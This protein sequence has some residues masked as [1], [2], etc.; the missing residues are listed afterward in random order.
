MYKKKTNNQFLET[1]LTKLKDWH[2]FKY[3]QGSGKSTSLLTLKDKSVGYISISK[4]INAQIDIRQPEMNWQS[5]LAE[6]NTS[7]KKDLSNYV[8]S[9]HLTCNLVNLW[10]WEYR[11]E[12]LDILFL[13]EADISL[14]GFFTWDLIQKD[15]RWVRSYDELMFR[16]T[17]TPLVLFMGAQS[18]GIVRLM[19][20]RIIKRPH[21]LHENSYKDLE[22]KQ[23]VLCDNSKQLKTLIERQ[24]EL[25]LSN[26]EKHGGVYVASENTDL[27]SVLSSDWIKR[28][29]ELKTK[30]VVKN[31]ALSNEELEILADPNKQQDWDLMLCSPKTKD[32][33]H[34]IGGFD[35][36]AGR[37]SGKAL[38]GDEEV[39]NALLRVRTCKNFA[40][41]VANT[42]S[43][44]KNL[45][46]S[47]AFEN[48]QAMLVSVLPKFRRRNRTTGEIERTDSDLQLFTQFSELRKKEAKYGRKITIPEKLE[49]RGMDITPFIGAISETIPESK[50]TR[51]DKLQLVLEA[52]PYRAN[53]WGERKDAYRLIN[54]E[55]LRVYGEVNGENYK[56]WDGGN[57]L[58]NFKRAQELGQTELNGT[59]VNEA[60]V[61]V[62]KWQIENKKF[63]KAFI[64]ARD[65]TGKYQIPRQVLYDSPMWKQLIEDKDQW[66]TFFGRIGL[67]DIEIKDKHT[68]PDTN[69]GLDLYMRLLRKFNY[70][71]EL[72]DAKPQKDKTL[73]RK[74][75]ETKYKARLKEWRANGNSRQGLEKFFWEKL[76]TGEEV[77]S[78]I[79]DEALTFLEC[80]PYVL[81]HKDRLSHSNYIT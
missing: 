20:E 38:I 58:E 6:D 46:S 57:F 63:M 81:I 10:V 55:I 70:T 68:N 45:K 60:R 76:I 8:S 78:D 29:P 74:L 21:T 22:G 62:D 34:V 79:T 80:F 2:E 56:R 50:K 27:L 19:N 9:Q 59:P 69:L 44:E 35:L 17:T 40:L 71:A 12:P 43:V 30:I 14:E 65:K 49:E 32:G 67:S 64:V 72:V 52:K 53:E 4:I 18:N 42:K 7:I 26:R 39:I 31:K 47:D 73:T 3:H 15:D 77:L 75:A 5:H 13:D 37:Y 16:L 28:F 36:V 23:C 61:E 41:H 25:R 48:P 54:T 1:D 24:L 33:M 11:T 66:N 51:E